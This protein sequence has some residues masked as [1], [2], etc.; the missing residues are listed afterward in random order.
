MNRK[1]LPTVHSQLVT[2]LRFLESPWIAS[3]SNI[4]ARIPSHSNI[5]ASPRF[6]N[7][8]SRNYEPSLPFSLSVGCPEFR[9]QLHSH[10]PL[11]V[12]LWSDDS[13]AIAG[14][15]SP[16]SILPRVRFQVPGT[17][18]TSNGFPKASGKWFLLMPPLVPKIQQPPHHWYICLRG[19]I[20]NYFGSGFHLPFENSAMTRTSSDNPWRSVGE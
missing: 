9:G 7:I 14:K 16:P 13:L 3:A 12:A 10:Q 15:L 20:A 6:D 11:T 2:P 18:Q 8:I 4:A 17:L 1:K 5:S 19:L